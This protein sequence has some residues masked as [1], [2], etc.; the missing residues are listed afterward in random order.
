M[1]SNECFSFTVLVYSRGFL[2]ATI[3]WYD[4]P[5]NVGSVDNLLLNNLDLSIVDH[6]G[7]KWVGND[8]VTGGEPD[9]RNPQEQVSIEDA[10]VGRYMVYV[11]AGELAS[12]M[13]HVAVVIT[14]TGYVSSGPVSVSYVPDA[15]RVEPPSTELVGNGRAEEHM[16]VFSKTFYFSTLLSEQI[17]YSLGSFNVPSSSFRFSSVDAEFSSDYTT[18]SAAMALGIVITSPSGHTVQLGGVYDLFTNT[19]VW[20]RSWPVHWSGQMDGGDPWD[21]TRSVD[22][23]GLEEAGVWQICLQLFAPPDIAYTNLTY[24]PYAGSITVNFRINASAPTNTPSTTPPTSTMRPTPTA[25]HPVVQLH[26]KSMLSTTVGISLLIIVIS[27]FAFLTV[28]VFI[29]RVQR[30]RI[31]RRQAEMFVKAPDNSD[32]DNSLHSVSSISPRLSPSVLGSMS[33]LS[34]HIRAF[35][36]SRISSSGHAMPGFSDHDLAHL[37]LLRNMTPI[38]QKL[39]INTRRRDPAQDFRRDV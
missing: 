4:P 27:L 11:C 8:A 29:P 25:M 38:H 1:H 30:L 20:S 36:S 9:Y 21:A 14:S 23:V 34:S 15:V 28:A 26:T 17:P 24:L 19:N 18:G 2:K 10:I 7:H 31:A 5:S 39:G 35:A 6:G 37:Q 32:G 13:Q 3:A 33:S 16:V 22:A 12:T